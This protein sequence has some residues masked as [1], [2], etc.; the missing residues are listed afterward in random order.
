MPPC[1]TLRTIRK[2]SASRSPGANRCS[3]KP[4]YIGSSRKSCMR[5]F[6][7][8]YS[9]TWLNNS[10]SPSQAARR[11]AARESGRWARVSSTR[12]MTRSSPCALGMARLHTR[13]QPAP[14]VAPASLHGSELNAHGI[15]RLFVG[16][17]EEE[18]HFHKGAPFRLR[19]RQFVQQPVYSDGQIHF[20]AIGR[21]N[22]FE[23]FQRRELRRG[24]PPRVIDQ[25]P[26]HSSSSYSVK[27]LPILPI[28]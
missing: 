7:S 26:A 25:I 6:H 27:M 1:A 17:T 16:K 11:K 22:V 21:K 23:P 4:G 28:P 9:H 8:T 18:L 12:F 10:V 2:R 3:H 13:K 24:P 14:R 5:W 15:G 20:A 19:L